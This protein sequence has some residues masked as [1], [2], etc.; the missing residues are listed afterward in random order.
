MDAFKT[1]LQGVTWDL[2]F[3]SQNP[4]VSYSN[5]YSIFS[6][7]FCKYFPLLTKRKKANYSHKSYITPD[8]VELIKEKTS[9]RGNMPSGP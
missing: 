3:S 4:N 2:V 6:A 1:A 5:F 9:C 8:L 7:C